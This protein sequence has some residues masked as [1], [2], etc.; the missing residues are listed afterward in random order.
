MS[1]YKHEIFYSKD[2]G[3]Y[4]ARIPELPLCSAF[5][6]TKEE[7]LRELKIAE[8]LHLEVRGD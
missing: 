7:A 5:G 3:G 8:K 1:K 4:I 6:E 2:D